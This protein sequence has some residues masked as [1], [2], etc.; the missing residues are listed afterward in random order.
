MTEEIQLPELPELSDEFTLKVDGESREIVMK[1]AMLR[2][3]ARAFPGPSDP[4]LVF[5]DQI[6][7]ETAL[8]ILLAPRTKTGKIDLPEDAD[9]TIDDIDFSE[10]EAIRL[11]KWAME[12]VL[13]FFLKKF[14]QLTK[15]GETH[16]KEI[17]TLL[18]S[19]PG[20]KDL[21]SKKASA[22]P[23]DFSTLLSDSSTGT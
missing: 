14:N 4:Q 8:S 23:T 7:F 2:E 10:D 20:L 6:M 9:W 16:L 12:H 1:F 19:L 11:V 13:G 22:G 3:L 5:H 21:A 18:S 15:L 17:E